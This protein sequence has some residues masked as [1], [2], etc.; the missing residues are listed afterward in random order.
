[1]KKPI[2]SIEDRN[3]QLGQHMQQYRKAAHVTQQEM[4][5]FCDASKNHLSKI[6]Q[7]VC[8]CP[9]HIFIDYGKRL[10]V[11]LD[12]LANSPTPSVPYIIPE[13]QTAISQLSR[14]KQQT[15]VTIAQA[16]AKD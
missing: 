6:E 13:L 16:L 3:K 1:M 11:S 2:T 7:G 14:Q 9:A 5:E 15:L 8:K 4:S 12:E 10:N